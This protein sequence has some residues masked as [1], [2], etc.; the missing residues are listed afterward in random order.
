MPGKST[1]NIFPKV[2]V[3][4]LKWCVLFATIYLATIQVVYNYNLY[5][6]GGKLIM[7]KAN[8]VAAVSEKTGFT[9]KD[10]EKAIVAVIDV[11]K[12]ALENGEKVSLVGF[13]T[14]SVKE[15]A[16]HEGRNPLTGE[17]KWIEASKAP[18]F[19]AGSALKD[20]INK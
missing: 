7:T 11:I 18:V 15:R 12:E 1:L 3:N 19:K 13:G 14:F 6:N 20:A 8:L 10:S 5:I 9:K 2:W 16:A 17:K 4:V